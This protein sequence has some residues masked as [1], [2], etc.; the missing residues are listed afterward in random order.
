MTTAPRIGIDLLGSDTPPEKLFHAVIDCFS[1]IEHPVNLTVFGTKDL[2]LHI[3]PPASIQCIS[4]PEFI[5]MEDSP[6][7]AVRKKKNSS[8]C[9]G[10]KMIKSYDLDAFI[11][12]GNT[13]A[14]LACCKLELPML[15]G[16]DRPAL[17]TLIPT[18]KEPMAVLDVGANVSVTAEHLV[19]FASMGIA[20][21]KTRGI[22]Q[23]TVGLLNIGSEKKKGTPELRKAY[24]HLQHELNRAQMLSSPIFVGNVE[25]RDAFLGDID[26]LVTDGFSGNIFLKTAEGLA[27]FILDDLQKA[28]AFECSIEL[29]NIISTLRR[30]LRYDEYPGAILCG[31]EG[32]VMKCH[33]RSSALSLANSIKGAMRL[34]QHFFLEKIKQELGDFKER[35][36]AP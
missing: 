27:E 19:Q 20:Y 28:G 30:R 1:H 16:I 12:A 17:M 21:Q 23:P 3:K 15:P 5:S 24:E 35:K 33:G 25:G 7:T 13:G 18:K 11:T 6:L 2:F 10:I 22:K 26:V 34:S 36:K 32:I 29:K 4:V 31:V 14:L 8:L 9:L